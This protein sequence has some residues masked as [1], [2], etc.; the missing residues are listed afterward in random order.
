MDQGKFH[1]ESEQSCPSL[2]PIEGRKTIQLD[3]SKNARKL[4]VR[5]MISCPEDEFKDYK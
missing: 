5:I 2:V 4:D 3:G 1:D